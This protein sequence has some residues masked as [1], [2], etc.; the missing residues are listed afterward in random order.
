MTAAP[1]PNLKL[2]TFDIRQL[3]GA[4]GSEARALF[5]ETS[6]SRL[7]KTRE[8]RGVAHLASWLAQKNS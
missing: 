2:L 4:D 8:F 1:G 5:S 7:Q 3:R 6:L